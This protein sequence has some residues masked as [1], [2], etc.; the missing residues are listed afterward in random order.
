MTCKLT[1]LRDGQATRGVG[2]GLGAARALREPVAYRRLSGRALLVST[3]TTSAYSC[4]GRRPRPG[5]LFEMT[6]AEARL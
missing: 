1:D 2:P 3:P 4:G 6:E 5:A